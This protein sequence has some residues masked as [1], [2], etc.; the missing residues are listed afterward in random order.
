VTTA[1]HPHQNP[2]EQ[3]VKGLPAWYF[4]LAGL[5]V[6]SFERN[7]DDGGGQPF[8]TG[9]RCQHCR[10]SLAYWLQDH[11]FQVTLVEKGS[12]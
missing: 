8:G 9:F 4:G 2:A 5:L 11:G 12:R 3:Q 10:A 7:G 1:Q 6:A